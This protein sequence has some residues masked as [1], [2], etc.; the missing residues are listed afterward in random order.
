M[1]I[2]VGID[3][4]TKSTGIATV[5]SYNGGFQILQVRL[6]RAKGRL[7]ADRRVEMAK[8]LLASINC[9]TLD[10]G[11]LPTAVAVEWMKLRPREKRPNDIVN[12]NGIAGMCVAASALL[13]P[14]YLFTPIP[15][16]WKGTVPKKI[17]QAR[18]LSRLHLMP[19]LTYQ[20]GYGTGSVPGSA[21][22]P[23]S[24]RTH[25]IDALGLAVWAL[26]P[27]G[28]VHSARISAREKK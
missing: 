18:I 17:H 6:A 11:Y 8:S 26:D 24:M 10:I 13:Y 12:L 21:D 2:A 19:D 9:E 3:P 1:M 15:Q 7:A 27:L 16:E 14:E 22:I 5:Q 28:P 23:K 20:K 25:V 4:D